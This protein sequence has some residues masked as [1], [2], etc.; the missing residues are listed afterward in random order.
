MSGP[1]YTTQ[2]NKLLFFANQKTGRTLW[3]SYMPTIPK[4]DELVANTDKTYRVTRVAGHL[5]YVISA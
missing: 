3:R 1:R 4:V 5:I 2:T